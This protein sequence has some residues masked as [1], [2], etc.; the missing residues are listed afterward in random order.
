ME[1]ALKNIQKE[2]SKIKCYN[3]DRFIT[4]EKEN[5]KA[6]YHTKIMM[7][8]YKFK[9]HDKKNVFRLS[10]RN[11]FNQSKVEEIFLYPVKER[12]KFIGIFYGYRKPIKAPIIPII[13]YEINGFRKLNSFTRAYYREFRFEKGN[14]FCYFKGIF[15][16]LKKRNT[17]YGL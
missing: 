4:I 14:V 3:K 9:I 6:M 7:D 12:N 10:L 13:R 15:R 1:S 16:L 8:I 5:G 2:K 11:L 17:K